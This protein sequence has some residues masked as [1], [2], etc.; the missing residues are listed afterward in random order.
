M[1]EGRIKKVNRKWIEDILLKTTYSKEL[2]KEREK[3]CEG[4]QHKYN[5]SIQGISLKL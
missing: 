4:I 1:K 5:I 2:G 3:V